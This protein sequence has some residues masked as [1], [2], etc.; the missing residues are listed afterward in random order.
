MSKVVAGLA[1][2]LDGFIADADD[3]VWSLFGWLTDG[4]TPLEIMGQKFMTSPVSAAHYREIVATT[5]AAVT[6]RRDFD[7]SRAWGG[8]YPMGNIPVFIVTHNPPPEWTGPDSPFRF[9]TD[10]VESAIR[11]AQQAAGDQDVSVNGSQIVRQALK[12]GLIDEF[13][14]ELVP[15]LLGK[16]IRLFEPLGVEPVQLEIAGVAPAPTVTHLKYRVVK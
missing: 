5:G 1:M 14:I 8:N 13:Q 15:V 16:G 4:D 12:A 3:G 10:G 9:V 11:Q 7:I 6:G 2:S